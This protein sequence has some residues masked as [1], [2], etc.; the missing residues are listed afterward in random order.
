LES[1]LHSDA[2]IELENERGDSFGDSKLE[3]VVGSDQLHS[4]SEFVKQLFS[5][6]PVDTRFTRSAE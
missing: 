4:P 3:Q 6:S 2:V 5:D 1:L